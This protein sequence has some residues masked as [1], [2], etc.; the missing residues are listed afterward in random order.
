[1]GT[2]ANAE[3]AMG[4]KKGERSIGLNESGREINPCCYSGST[5]GYK[6]QPTRL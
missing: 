1:M 6:Q 2:S 4:E 5:F 3:A